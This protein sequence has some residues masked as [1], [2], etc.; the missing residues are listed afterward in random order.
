M[1]D[2]FFIH[3]TDSA[4]RL[5]V[6]RPV[7]S[8]ALSP[9]CMAPEDVDF[10]MGFGKDAEILE[11]IG[12]NQK[13]L[14][15]FAQHYGKSYRY[16]NFFHCQLI[17][18]FSP[19]ADLASLERVDIGWNI[20]ADR[21]WDM[22][23]NR[24]LHTLRLVDARRMIQNPV[25]LK[26]APNLQNLFLA[27]DNLKLES[28]ELF[29]GM[30]ALRHLGFHGVKLLDS[31]MDALATLPRLERF[32]F[33]PG[34]LTTEEIAWIV[35]KYPHLIGESLCPY[36]SNHCGMSDIRICGYR[37]PGLNLPKG[38]KRL[39]KYVAEFNA[40]VEQYRREL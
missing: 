35:A 2:E 7:K 39:D 8:D 6:S 3:V 18:D 19:L 25:G 17:R 11:I 4:K 21:L 16:L 33:D 9:C 38:Q 30:P 13:S 14:E 1:Q 23:Q 29:A 40:L 5:Y 24:K 34:M 15:H 26:T 10:E 37:K 28:M 12:M 20:R 36:T 27:G 32:D 31:R 22:T